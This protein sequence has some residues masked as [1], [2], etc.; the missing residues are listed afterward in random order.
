V[1]VIL[2]EVKRRLKNNLKLLFKEEPFFIFNRG[3]NQ[4]TS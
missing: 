2:D 1:R 4:A 3:L